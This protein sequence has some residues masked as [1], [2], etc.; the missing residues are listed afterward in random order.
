MWCDNCGA[1]VDAGGI[2][3]RCGATVRGG[4]QRQQAAPPRPD[5]TAK[6]RRPGRNGGK[7]GTLADIAQPSGKTPAQRPPARGWRDRVSRGFGASS[8][9]SA[10]AAPR[11]GPRAARQAYPGSAPPAV[12]NHP[13]FGSSPWDDGGPAD[14]E[15]AGWGVDDSARDILPEQAGWETD[16]GWSVIMPAE[17]S[18][19]AA[20]NSGS[21]SSWRNHSPMVPLEVMR[22]MRV[23]QYDPRA[24][25][26]AMASRS[27]RFVRSANTIA[28]NTVLIS[29][30]LLILAIPVYI[31]VQHLGVFHGHASHGTPSNKSEPTPALAQGF[32]G[33]E[34][35]AFS[36][37]YPASWT[38]A[39]HV[40]TLDCKC[41][42]HEQAFTGPQHEE[43]LVGEMTA[44]SSDQ[45]QG[46]L[47]AAVHVTMQGAVP[48]ALASNVI[49]TYDHQS[50]I[51]N[52]YT[53]TQVYGSAAVQMQVRALAVDANATTYVVLAIGPQASF[54]SLNASLFE[55]ALV[56]FRFQ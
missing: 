33:F 53:I 16:Q 19:D 25:M 49:K 27:R 46:V 32:T 34:N 18:P 1:Y 6:G 52:D 4:G 54:A 56:S 43:L 51:E 35:D 5:P 13:G 26:P 28:F 21:L 31:G 38:S 37:A 2:C 11:G 10:D 15:S 50:W 30:I 29:L 39:M 45:L 14:E 47:D 9:R 20:P 41:A 7:R 8:G 12:E 36:I 48:Q 44:V 22:A 3:G 23:P 40:D 24:A 55:P 42:L 17:R